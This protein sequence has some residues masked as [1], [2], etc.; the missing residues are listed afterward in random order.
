MN[1]EDSEGE[2][3]TNV[4]NHLVPNSVRNSNKKLEPKNLKRGEREKTNWT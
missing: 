1:T 2:S 4:V 3:E